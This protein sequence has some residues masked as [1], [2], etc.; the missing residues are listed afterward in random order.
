MIEDAE[1]VGMFGGIAHTLARNDGLSLEDWEAWFKDYDLS[2][3]MAIIHFTPFR[4]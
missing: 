3:P 2:K 1:R 4:Y